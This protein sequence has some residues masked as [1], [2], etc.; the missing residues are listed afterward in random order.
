MVWA[1]AK[2][3]STTEAQTTTAGTSPIWS[4]AKM[5]LKAGFF[6]DLSH[7]LYGRVSR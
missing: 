4:A 5:D 6:M 2:G 1:I 3:G 7:R